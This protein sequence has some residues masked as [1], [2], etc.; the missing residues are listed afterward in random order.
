MKFLKEQPGRLALLLLACGAAAVLSGCLGSVRSTIPTETAREGQT[1][2]Q[3]ASPKATPTPEVQIYEDEAMLRGSQAVLG[4]TVQNLSGAELQNLKVE[5]ELKRRRDDATET[6]TVEVKPALLA[7]GAK[8][9]YALTVS[10]EWGSA[11]IVRLVGAN[12]TQDIAYVSTRGALRPPE[13]L[14]DKKTVGEPVARPRPKG[15]EYLN[16]PE[17]A[18]KYP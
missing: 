6:R 11:R 9:R 7:A 2:A 5:F 17:T 18:D 3:S 15:E 4:G 14:P 12:R 16:T 8:G 13:R 10:R 1:A